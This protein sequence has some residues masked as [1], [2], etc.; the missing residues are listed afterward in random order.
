MKQTQIQFRLS[1]KEKE[2]IKTASKISNK[3]MSEFILN[4]VVSTSHKVLINGFIDYDSTLN[5]KVFKLFK[6]EN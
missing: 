4:S 6:N 3:G 2:L 5:S 1:A